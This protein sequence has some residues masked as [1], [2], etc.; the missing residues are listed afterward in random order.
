MVLTALPHLHH[1]IDVAGAGAA[2]EL[3]SVDH[4]QDVA[5]DVFYGCDAAPWDGSWDVKGRLIQQV[6]RDLTMKSVPKLT[7]EP[8]CPPVPC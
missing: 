7:R 8:F 2:L 3:P 1:C 4:H 5:S 6:W